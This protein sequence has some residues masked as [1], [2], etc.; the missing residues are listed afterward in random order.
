MSKVTLSVGVLYDIKEFLEDIKR[1]TITPHEFGEAFPTFRVASGKRVLEMS[2]TLDWVRLSENKILELT[3]KGLRIESC[4]S[5]AAAL[6]LQL[7][8]FILAKKPPWASLI[9]KGR[10]ETVQYLDRDAEQCFREAA[11]LDETSDEVV[12]WWDSLAKAARGQKED[13][14][15]DTG[16]EESDAPSTTNADVR[17]ALPS[18]SP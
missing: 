8:D 17:V 5:S 2:Q 15:L 3:E 11:L 1:T 12:R 9:P 13:V 18:G 7:E 4:K 16:R 14:N 10:A 6:R